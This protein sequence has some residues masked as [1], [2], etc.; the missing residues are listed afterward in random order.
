VSKS[1]SSCSAKIRSISTS[2]AIDGPITGRYGSGA[3]RVGGQRREERRRDVGDELCVGDQL[4]PDERVVDR[5]HA[6]GLDRHHAVDRPAGGAQRD[7]QDVRGLA[8][9]Q[10]DAALVGHR[11]A[12]DLELDLAGEPAVGPA[13][14]RAEVGVDGDRAAV[15][16]DPA[17][18][19]R[20]G[21]DHVDAGG[22]AGQR[23]DREQ[24]AVAIGGAEV[25]DAAQDAPLAGPRARV[26]RIARE[27][28]LGAQPR[29][30]SSR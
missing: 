8:R 1:I 25:D 21:H 7:E 20:A 26:E 14:D 12:P 29:R 18:G 19:A 22:L 16:G 30:S 3:A 11:V 6:V 2:G 5:C 17:P 13:L 15:L 23:V 28:Q 27:R 10:A 4:G 24:P 9:E